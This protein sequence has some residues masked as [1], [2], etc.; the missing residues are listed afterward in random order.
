MNDTDY[1]LLVFRVPA[2][3]YESFTDAVF[4]LGCLGIE[5][6]DL[7]DTIECRCWFEKDPRFSDIV[8]R[9]QKHFEEVIFEKEESI[10]EE[11]WNLNWR[12]NYSPVEIAPGIIVRPSWDKSDL[13]SY[14]KIITIDPKLTFGTGHHETTRLCALLLQKYFKDTKGR[15]MDVGT[16][17]GLLS[18]TAALYGVDRITAFD[19]DQSC[20]ENAPSNFRLNNV[21]G[22]SCFV[23]NIHSVKPEEIF[24]GGCANIISSILFPLIPEIHKRLM[25]GSVF[26]FSGILGTEKEKASSLLDGAGFILRETVY[27]N[28]WIAIAAEKRCNCFL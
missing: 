21:S 15:F 27:E 24:E 3:N 5:D 14:D 10:P 17:T 18:V 1:N 12:K 8:P 20:A 26:I 4:G 6:K 28:E 23:G 19:I 25:S 2:D 16:G 11:D 22:I 13:S 9:I 7:G